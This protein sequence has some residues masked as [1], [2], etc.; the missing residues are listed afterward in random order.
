MSLNIAVVCGSVRDNRNSL[1][2]SKYFVK[3]LQATG[4]TGT[5]VDFVE[6]PLPFVNSDPNP[7]KLNKNYPDPNIQEW[8]RIADAADAFIFVA[9][10]YNHGLSGVLKNALDW[11]YP[12]FKHK[13]AALVGVSN[14]ASAGIRAVEMLR[15]IM[16]VFAIY[17]IREGVNFASAQN[18]FDADA[19]LLDESYQKR[20]DG[21][22]D[23]LAKV[24]EVMKGLR[25][26]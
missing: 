4:H 10:E 2:V 24:A 12:E 15:P 26:N 6:L 17:D 14:G 7:S 8:S 19:N 1:T 5:L 18:V 22:I 9:P 20:I 11:L 25:Q 21:M 3:K 16:A 13:P 23:S